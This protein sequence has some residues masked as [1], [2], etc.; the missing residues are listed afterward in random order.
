MAKFCGNCGATMDDNASVCGM[1]GTPFADNEQYYDDSTNNS[2]DGAY[3]NGGYDNFGYDN[4]GYNNGTVTQPPLTSGQQKIKK[5]IIFG[6]VGL[7]VVIILIVVITI[8]SSVFVTGYKKALNNIFDGINDKD[9]DKFFDGVST[10]T[11]QKNLDDVDDDDMEDVRKEF[12][13]GIAELMD[14]LEDEYGDKV[15]KNVK[16]VYEVRDVD[17]LSERKTE[18]LLEYIEKH[19]KESDVDNIKEIKVVDVKIKVK[20]SK[21]DRKIS[22]GKCYLL[23]DNGKW[24]L[25]IGYIPSDVGNSSDSALLPGISN[26]F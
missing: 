14:N 10:V 7:G 16:L 13:D 17:D 20:G 11:L 3:Q 12:E 26:L 24:G 19:Y 18:K 22:S 23:N 6:A 5:G 2:Y 25:Y 8:L 15:G 1:C 21:D 9:F 4:G